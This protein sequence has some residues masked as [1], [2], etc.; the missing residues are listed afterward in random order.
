MDAEAQHIGSEKYQR[1]F[2]SAPLTTID[3]AHPTDL[4]YM[5][6]WHEIYRVLVEAN[7]TFGNLPNRRRLLYEGIK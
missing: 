2:A 5:V 7:Y 1:N 4:L 6:M 3:E